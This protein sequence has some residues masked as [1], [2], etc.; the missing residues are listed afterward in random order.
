MKNGPKSQ[1]HESSNDEQANKID[2]HNGFL[3]KKSAI[4]AKVQWILHDIDSELSTPNRENKDWNKLFTW[5]DHS[6]SMLNRDVES[7][8]V[9]EITGTLNSKEL[10]DM[11][12]QNFSGDS[13]VYDYSSTNYIMDVYRFLLSMK[14]LN[15]LNQMLEEQRERIDMNEIEMSL[16]QRFLKDKIS[17]DTSMI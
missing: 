17:K 5:V 13:V 8:P 4:Q 14:I 10:Y 2:V 16:S 7:F 3:A 11:R 1:A 6:L 15:S 12:F 9:E